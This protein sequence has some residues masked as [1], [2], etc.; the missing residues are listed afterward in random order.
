MWEFEKHHLSAKIS[1]LPIA[2]VVLVLGGR[3]G[4]GWYVLIHK[5]AEPKTEVTCEFPHLF[6]QFG[7]QVANRVEIVLHGEREVHQIVQINRVVLHRTHLNLKWGLV[8]WRRQGSCNYWFGTVTIQSVCRYAYQA[9]SWERSSVDI[10]ARRRTGSTRTAWNLE[11][12]SSGEFCYS[13]DSLWKVRHT[14]FW[15]SSGWSHI[16]RWVFSLVQSPESGIK[17][18]CGKLC[19]SRKISK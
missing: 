2:R 15:A 16:V 4:E 17:D 12:C 7:A 3:V 1:G 5:R 13:S 11:V 6:R 10:S 18:N 9:L 14:L 8:T 19:V